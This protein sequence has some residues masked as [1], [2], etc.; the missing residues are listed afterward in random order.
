MPCSNSSS[1]HS[2]EVPHKAVWLQLPA[3]CAVPQLQRL[4]SKPMQHSL[5]LPL[6]WC[7]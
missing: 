6:T 2:K 5:G 1:S 3:M 7:C 4:P